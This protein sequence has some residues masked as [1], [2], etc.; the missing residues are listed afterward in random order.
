MLSLHL[1]LATEIAYYAAERAYLPLR[2]FAVLTLY[3]RLLQLT[4][5]P[6]WILT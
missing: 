2:A 4:L 3:V 1:L 6:P 5:D